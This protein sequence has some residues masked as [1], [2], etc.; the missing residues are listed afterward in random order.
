MDEEQL[1][2]RRARK[3]ARQI[4]ED[5][6]EEALKILA[7]AAGR[8]VEEMRGE[9]TLDLEEA[10]IAQMKEIASGIKD[11][12]LSSQALVKEDL[13][14]YKKQKMAEIDAQIKALVEETANRVVKKILGESIDLKNH[15]DLVM[16]AVEDAKRGG[17][18]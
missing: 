16:K 11:Q 12:V 5:A 18:F 17:I 13:E 8:Q 15:E 1:K 4:V 7:D 6:R 3:K 9:I 14:A 2:L 10:A